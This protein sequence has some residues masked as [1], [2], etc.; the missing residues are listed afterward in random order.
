MGFRTD[1]T[2]RILSDDNKV[3]TS[4]VAVERRDIKTHLMPTVV[5]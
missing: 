3:P 2:H 1:E 4:N 5:A